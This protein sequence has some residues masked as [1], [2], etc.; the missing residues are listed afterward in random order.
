MPPISR[1]TSGERVGV[2][3][4]VGVGAVLGVAE[5]SGDAVGNANAEDDGAPL[6]TVAGPHAAIQSR[7]IARRRVRT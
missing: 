6:G 3:A 2:A 7:A 1:V 4:G 5:G